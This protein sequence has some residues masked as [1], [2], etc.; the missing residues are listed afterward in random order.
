LVAGRDAPQ[1]AEMPSRVRRREHW[2][3]APAPWAESRVAPRRP[4]PARDAPHAP[5]RAA[6]RSGYAFRDVLAL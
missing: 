5:C 4:V 1:T 2:T 3:G 6:V